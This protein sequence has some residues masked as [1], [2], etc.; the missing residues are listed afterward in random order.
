LI[1]LIRQNRAT[2]AN[3]VLNHVLASITG[4][5]ARKFQDDVTLLKAGL[6]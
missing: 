3:S 1:G 6:A 2:S 4:H 5:A